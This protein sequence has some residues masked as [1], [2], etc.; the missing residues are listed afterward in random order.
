MMI[1][2]FF[3]NRLKFAVWKKNFQR[4]HFT[5]FWIYDQ[6]VKI[7]S[8]FSLFVQP[9]KPNLVF[10]RR[11]WFNLRSRGFRLRIKMFLNFGLR[12]SLRLGDPDDDENES[13]EREG[14][15]KPED[16]FELHRLLH[17][18]VGV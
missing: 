8:Q 18:L 15:V 2:K 16:S 17:V 9:L 10:I 6:S 12:L 13:Q 1:V 4:F 5:F 3:K 11:Q 7:F 14:S